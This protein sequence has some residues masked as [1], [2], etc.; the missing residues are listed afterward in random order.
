MQA[1][2]STLYDFGLPKV[3]RFREVGIVRLPAGSAGFKALPPAT[4][5]VWRN[6]HVVGV[7]VG[8]QE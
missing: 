3:L 4:S 7:D 6:H 2:L 8:H 5:R 1:H